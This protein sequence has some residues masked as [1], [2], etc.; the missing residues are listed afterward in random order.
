MPPIAR[1][2][3]EQVVTDAGLILGFASR[4][5][6]WDVSRIISCLGGP[7]LRSRLQHSVLGLCCGVQDL[8]GSGFRIWICVYCFRSLDRALR[9]GLAL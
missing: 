7:V 1:K 6:P 5:A 4:V 8:Q 2:A 9:H 3:R